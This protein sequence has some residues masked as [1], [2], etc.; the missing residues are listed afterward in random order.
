[1]MNLTIQKFH[2]FQRSS[3]ADSIITIYS[4]YSRF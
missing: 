1:M 2:S 3:N 4:T